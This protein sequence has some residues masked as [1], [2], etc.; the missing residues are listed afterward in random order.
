MKFPDTHGRFWP[1]FS[2]VISQINVCDH[3]ISYIEGQAYKSST[4]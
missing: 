3:N 1:K 4:L 2:S